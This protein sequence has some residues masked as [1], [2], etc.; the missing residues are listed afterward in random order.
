MAGKSFREDPRRKMHEQLTRKPAVK[1][2]TV[3]QNIA[4]ASKVIDSKTQK[5]VKKEGL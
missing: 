5:T 3:S 2:P 4:D 1:A